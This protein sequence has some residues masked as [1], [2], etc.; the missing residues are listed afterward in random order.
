MGVAAFG[1][2]GLYATLVVVT[3]GSSSV[4]TPLMAAVVGLAIFAEPVVGVYVL[5]GIA[6]LFEQFVITG[7]EPITA[8]T[9]LYQNLSAY[10]PIPLRLSI[11][12]LLIGLTFACWA[13]R[14]Q[15]D[16]RFRMGPLGWAV[17]AYAAVFFIGLVIGAARGG[18]F[19]SVV[20]LAE[21]HGPLT[22][23]FLY[24]LAANLIRTRTQLL[25]LMWEFLAVIGLKAFEDL[26]NYRDSL[27]VHFGVES[28]TSH[29]DVIF[30]GLAIVV[31]MVL[32]VLGVRTRY[33]WTLFALQ[34]LILAG[35]LVAA[36][37]A[38]FI[39]LG[40]VFLVTIVLTV[41]GN[42]RRGIVLAAIGAVAALAYIGVFWDAE[43]TF[44][45]PLRALRSV[46][47]PGAVAFRDQSSNLWRDIENQN[48]AFTMRQLPFTGV[49]LGQE[50][51][52]QREPVAIDGFPYWRY[53]THN[54]LLWLWLK[55]GPLG[56]FALWFLVARVLLVGSALYL[57]LRRS[58]LRWVAVAP[59]ALMVLQI[60]FSAVDLGLTYSRTMIVLGTIL[61]VTAFLVE[62]DKSEA[63]AGTPAAAAIR[64]SAGRTVI[65]MPGR[66]GAV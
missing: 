8:Q 48:I 54:A 30:F 40:A 28:V 21:L 33:S 13:V 18:Q 12:D 57:R 11:A 32:A 39:A 56:A 63:A 37:R 3:N 42:G 52:F 25:I 35:E 43:G 15:R 5:F 19:D 44:A 51:I 2:A 26:M 38:G 36:R 60:V 7:L 49:G 23:C 17:V 10:T 62:H 4:L 29:E 22:A 34:P 20:A 64:P 31:A 14:R 9:R 27:S 55:A 45:G 16:E 53:E 41:T 58:D 24:F 61:G 46:I 65:R 66:V 50:Y 6:L 47:D 59:V 1:L